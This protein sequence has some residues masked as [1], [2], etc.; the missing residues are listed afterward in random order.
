M[1]RPG[2]LNALLLPIALGFLCLRARRL[3]APNR[4]KGVYAVFSGAIILMTVVFG[5]YSGVAGLWE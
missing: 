1:S 2:N 3:P 5:V 4:V